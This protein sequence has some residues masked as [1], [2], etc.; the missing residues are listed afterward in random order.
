MIKSNTDALQFGIVA[1][2][3]SAGIFILGYFAGLN[4]FEGT[5]IFTLL[6]SIVLLFYGMRYV[7]QYQFKANL[8]F[9]QAIK[10]GLWMVIPYIIIYSVLIGST[11]ALNVLDELPDRVRNTM[12]EKVEL[13]KTE[14]VEALGKTGFT[15]AIEDAQN[16]QLY[17]VATTHL[18]IRAMW[19]ILFTII[20]SV[21]FRT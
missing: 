2:L 19:L 18:M 13:K 8:S 3:V 11:I 20:A 7:K 5:T 12:I 9:I 17:S 1:S 16:I 15:K 4:P 14:I 21:Y 10:T 6:L